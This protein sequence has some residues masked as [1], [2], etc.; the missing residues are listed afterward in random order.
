MTIKER[1]HRIIAQ[2][3]DEQRD[4]KQQMFA[5]LKEVDINDEKEFF[6]VLTDSTLDKELRIFVCW[7]AGRLGDREALLGL[8][9]NLRDPEVGVRWTSVQSLGL[10][11]GE[12]AVEHLLKTLNDPSIEVKIVA[13]NTLGLIG[14]LKSVEPLIKIA[15]ETNE[16]EEVRGNAI[17]ALG[18]CGSK[19]AVEVLLELLNSP[20]PVIKFWTI[21]AL[22]QICDVRALA[23]LRRVAE[24]N[25]TFV[26]QYGIIADEAKDA[27]ERIENCISKTDRLKG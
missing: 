6:G 21:Y 4:Q 11:A 3:P 15:T 17:E 18:N 5:K 14:S 22:G 8:I 25:Q 26:S 23:P 10:L 27:I 13:I 7:V 16:P 2:L 20:S 19:E 1:V 9:R 24:T 12:E